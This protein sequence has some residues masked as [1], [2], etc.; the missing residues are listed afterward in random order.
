MFPVLILTLQGHRPCGG[1]AQGPWMTLHNDMACIRSDIHHCSNTVEHVLTT[2][3]TLL[4]RIS[5]H[6]TRHW[7]HCITQ[8]TICNFS[9]L[10]TTSNLN[11]SWCFHAKRSKHYHNGGLGRR[12]P[13]N[14]GVPSHNTTL[15][16]P[17][18]LTVVYVVAIIIYANLVAYMEG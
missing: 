12:R 9:V 18:N 4:Q 11:R 6:S 3:T 10:W 15:K 2:N 8:D 5:Q 7:I 14:L 17:S 16:R 13:G 1:S